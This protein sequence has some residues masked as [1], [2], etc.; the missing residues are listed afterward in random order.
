MHISLENTVDWRASACVC[1][2]ECFLGYKLTLDD[3]FI[4]KSE[5]IFRYR[6][7]QFRRFPLSVIV[8]NINININKSEIFTCRTDFFAIDIVCCVKTSEIWIGETQI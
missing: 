6:V 5:E 4:R 3:G 8:I 2:S 7:I 1:M